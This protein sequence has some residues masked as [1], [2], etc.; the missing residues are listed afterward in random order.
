MKKVIIIL[1]TYNEKG[2]IENLVEKIH[3]IS[4]KVKNWRLEILI[5]DDNS[6]DGTGKIAAKLA[7]QWQGV[8]FISGQKKG[9]GAAYVRGMDYAIKKMKAAVL[10]QMDAD[11]SHNPEKIPEFLKKIEKGYDFVIGGRY[12]KGGSIPQNWGVK[13]KIFSIGG[14]LIVR[15]ILGHFSISDWTSGFRAIKKDYFQKVRHSL[16]KYR[17]YTFQ[18]AFLHKALHNGAKVTEIPIHFIDRK[19]GQSKI[20]P[21]E[22]IVTLLIYIFGSRTKEIFESS[23]FKFCLVGLSGTA[24]DFSLLYLGVEYGNLKPTVAKIFSTSAA[25]VNNFVW[26]SLWTFGNRQTQNSPFKKFLNYVLVSLI[27]FFLAIGL[28]EIFTRISGPKYYILYNVIIVIL[29]TFWNYFA[30]SFWTFRE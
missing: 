26:N 4:K 6:P 29:V 14:N 19:Y 1:P 8:Y 18:I 10:F 20:I 24:I 12:L 21:P 17:G 25:I 28:M 15:S 2:N 3:E 23:F 30:N 22:Y 9:L 5:V 13:R 11:F 16:L 27:A 7:R